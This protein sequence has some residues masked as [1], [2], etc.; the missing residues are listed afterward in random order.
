MIATPNAVYLRPFLEMRL[1][2]ELLTVPKKVMVCLI[3]M[4][5][6]L[7]P[8]YS[9]HTSRILRSRMTTNL[10]LFY[11]YQLPIPRRPESDGAF[12]SIV[13]RAARLVCVSTDFDVLA[14]EVGL[15]GSEDG[16]TDIRERARLQAELDALVAHLYGLSEEEFAYVLT[17]FP[18]GDSSVKDAAMAAYKVLAPKSADQETLILIAE[19]EN[20]SLEFKSSAR[21]DFKEGK[22]SKVMEQV[23]L[24][25]VAGF[26]NVES[27]GTL[28]IGVN[29]E[30]KMVGLENDY[31]TMGKKPNRDGYENWLTALL[32]S[33]FGKDISPLIRIT[34]HVVDS[35]EICRVGLKSSHRPI[36]IKDGNN[37]HLY[38]RTGNSTRLLTSREAV[39]YCKQRW[40]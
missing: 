40:P 16:V 25:T 26:L 33:E 27:G 9:G 37:E 38:I 8:G 35:N 29:D 2:A 7:L 3:C 12:K 30:G 18:L 6:L 34:F 4:V 1:V 15:R 39:E 14:R 21:W 31:R 24:K 19:G 23:V 32:L 10:N 11:L 36:F 20:S 28:L 13:S 22:A 5:F 17:T